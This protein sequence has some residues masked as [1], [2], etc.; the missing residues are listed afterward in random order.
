MER[1]ARDGARR[2]T[3]PRAAGGGWHQIA[4]ACREAARPRS[5][6]TLICVSKTFDIPDIAPI[7]A[8]GQRDFGEPRQEARR[9]WPELRAAA[10]DLPCI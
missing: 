1:F 7:I 8:A 2:R 10:P 3:P 5:D 9:K 4:D 6:V